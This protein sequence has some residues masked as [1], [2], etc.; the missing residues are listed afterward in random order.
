VRRE[1]RVRKEGGRRDG[2]VRHR[3][4][5]G[6][7]AD[8]NRCVSSA[9]HSQSGETCAVK[10]VTNVFTKKVSLNLRVRTGHIAAAS[11]GRPR[12]ITTNQDR[13]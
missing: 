10:K 12:R 4:E 13:Y 3:E 5:R 1:G 2:M 9:R 8:L 6:E 7:G 11:G